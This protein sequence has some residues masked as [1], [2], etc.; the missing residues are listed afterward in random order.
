V[1]VKRV[2][3]ADVAVII[4]ANI[5]SYGIYKIADGCSLFFFF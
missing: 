2:R 4:I 5:L 3:K 1:S